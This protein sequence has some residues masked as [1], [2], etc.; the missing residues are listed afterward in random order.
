[1]K[2]VIQGVIETL[3]FI[4]SVL[5]TIQCFKVGSNMIRFTFLIDYSGLLLR[6]QC[7]RAGLD[8]FSVKDAIAVIH[9]RHNA[10]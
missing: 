10:Q 1:M 8:V 7:E 2:Q 3:D 4:L 5:G 6:G 9:E